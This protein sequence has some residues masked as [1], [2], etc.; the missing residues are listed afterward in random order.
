MNVEAEEQ[1]MNGH[2]VRNQLTTYAD[3]I[4]AFSFAQAVAF[5]YSMALG[6]GFAKTLWRDGGSWAATI[7]IVV[8]TALYCALV[9]RCIALT[10]KLEPT[11]GTVTTILSAIQKTRISIVLLSGGLSLLALWLTKFGQAAK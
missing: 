2:E 11:T 1:T 9:S 10:K 5:C 3:A 6:E 4:T 8:G 7:G